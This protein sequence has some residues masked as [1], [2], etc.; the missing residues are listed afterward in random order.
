MGI[1]PRQ[2]RLAMVLGLLLLQMPGA[3]PGLA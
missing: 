1:N 2:W 3:A